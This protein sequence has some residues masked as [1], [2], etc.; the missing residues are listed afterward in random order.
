MHPTLQLLLANVK[1]EG[2]TPLLGDDFNACI[3]PAEDLDYIDL[4][5]PC[6]MGSR[7]QQG[8]QG[9]TPARSLEIFQPNT[10]RLPLPPGRLGHDLAFLY[11]LSFLDFLR[12]I[13]SS[14]IP[15][16]WIWG[17]SGDLQQQ[18]GARKKKMSKWFG[19]ISL[20]PLDSTTVVFIACY[21]V[22][23]ERRRKN[24]YAYQ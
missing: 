18:K 4:V 14:W 6:G 11:G 9:K 23:C 21:A 17:N 7:N 1:R 2:R 20:W 16:R 24:M 15:A 3:G 22:L 10:R 13:S 12:W 5:G 8:T 19:M